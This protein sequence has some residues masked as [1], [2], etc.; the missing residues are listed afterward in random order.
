LGPGPAVGQDRSNIAPRARVSIFD[1][2]APVQR[3]VLKSGLTILVQEQRTSY[4]VA[5]AVAVRMG[6]IYES[7]DDAGRGQVLIKAILAGTQK[8]TSVELAL[9]LLAAEAQLESGAGPDLGQISIS[10]KREQVDTAIDLLAE[11]ALQPAFPDTAVDGMRQRAL[12]AAADQDENPVRASYS[13]FLGTMYHGSPLQR[14]V[15][16]TVSGLAGCRRKD[17]VALYKKYFVGGNM[18]VCFVGNFDG[19]KVMAHLEKA[20]AGTPS[21]KALEPYPGEPVPLAADTTITAQRDVLAPV[22]TFGYAAPGYMEPDYPAFKII[23]S[24]LVSP[25]RSPVT[26]WLPQAGIAAS[27]GVLYPPYPKRASMA[28]YFTA[29]P[30]QMAAA[31]DTV[32]AV[33]ARLRTQPLDEEEY[34]EQLKRVQEGT[35]ANQSDPLA[36]ARSMSQFEVAGA[37]YDFQRRFELTLLGLNA[38]RVRAAA[39]HWFTHSCESTITPF[40]TESKP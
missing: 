28:V 7:D 15:A 11:V 33:L 3:K 17:V 32:S 24:Y 18:V 21:G 20:F 23:E 4:R 25:D 29:A 12:T 27:V 40:K 26:F 6:T 22:M 19:K 36:R 39:E 38:E 8:I 37:G 10:T 14:S 5:G 13:M 9:R 34:A 30:N 35:F 31:R 1:A 16:G 2:G